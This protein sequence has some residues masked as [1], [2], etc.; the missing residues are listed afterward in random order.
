[1]RVMNAIE[2]TSEVSDN[3]FLGILECSPRHVR[4]V[5]FSRFGVKS[6]KKYGAGN[7]AQ[8]RAAKAGMLHA[9]LKEGSS[10]EEEELCHELLRNWLFT[11]RPMLKEALDFCDIENDNGIVEHDLDKLEKLSKSEVAELRTQLEKTYPAEEVLIYLKF[12][13][14]PHLA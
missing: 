13:D 8:R 10:K 12:M 11:K 2:L 3:L 6:K 9:K 1:M 4:E 14:V 7:F 5:L